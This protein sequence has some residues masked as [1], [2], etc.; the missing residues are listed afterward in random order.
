[1]AVTY[2]DLHHLVDELPERALADAQRLLEALKARGGVDPVLRALLTAPLD[3]EP[4]T[5][6]ERAAVEEGK[7]DLAAG[8]VV[9]HEEARRR[10]L[11]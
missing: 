1:M 7:A 8:R 6:E 11:G 3:D 9:S 10:L 4:E 5:A 2:A